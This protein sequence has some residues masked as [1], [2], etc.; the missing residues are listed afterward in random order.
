[1]YQECME[2]THTHTYRRHSYDRDVVSVTEEII[3]S[4]NSS[5]LQKPFLFNLNIT[6][7]ARLVSGQLTELVPAHKHISLTFISLVLNVIEGKAV[8]KQWVW[9]LMRH[10][11]KDLLLVSGVILLLISS[12]STPL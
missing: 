12:E 2:L 4:S 5:F 7:C 11:R 10:I 1:M 3:L 6:C 8:Q 9:E